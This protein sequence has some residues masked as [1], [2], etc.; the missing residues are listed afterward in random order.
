MVGWI[1]LDED[2]FEARASALAAD[3][4]ALA[5]LRQG[6]RDRVAASALF[7]AHRFATNLQNALSQ[8]AA[9]GTTAETRK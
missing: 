8:M 5:R 2:N 7:D 9:A 4:P 3:L 6:L 1:A